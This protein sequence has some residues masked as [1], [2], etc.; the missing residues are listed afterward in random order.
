METEMI[1]KRLKILS[2]L[3]EEM[4]KVKALYQESLEN[5]PQYQQIQEESQKFREETKEKRAK[6]KSNDTLQKLEEEVKKVRDEI[7]D[8][9]DI[10]AQELADY[11]RDT[12]SM[13]IVDPDG[14]V[15][16]FVFSFKFTGEAEE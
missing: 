8:N 6:V 15:K 1:S 14:K 11:Y 12:G 4:R 9:R 2:D 13:Q 3:Q 10:L 7:K 5:D 16:R